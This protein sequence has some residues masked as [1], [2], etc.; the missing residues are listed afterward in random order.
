M[1]L[2]TSYL[3]LK[4]KHP[5]IVGASPMAFSIDTVRRL[6]DAGAAALVMHSLFE[7]QVDDTG[8]RDDA[9]GADPAAEAKGFP[10][11]AE[12]YVNH[13]QHVKQVTDMPIIASLNGMREGSWVSYAQYLEQAGADALELNLY[14]LPSA[15]DES[16]AV[17]EQRAFQ[18]VR[19]VRQ[20]VSI[21]VAVKLSPFFTSLPHFAHRLEEAGATA[22]VLFN[23]FFQPDIDVRNLRAEPRLG[24]STPDELLLRLRWL[25]ALHGRLRLELSVTGGVHDV[26]G[27]VKSLMAGATSVQVVSALMKNGPEYLRTL[28]EGLE[29]WMEANQ[30]ED[31]EQMRGTMSYI[32]TNAVEVVSRAHYIKT[33]QQWRAAATQ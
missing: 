20:F 10:L 13:L 21:P 25:A 9:Y 3:G 17:V 7:E 23:R 31:M 18:I 33:L 24:Y 27:V 1:N 32:H 30:F 26:D 4:L 16:S 14:F 11:N 19:L 6:E 15:E 8:G 12:E 2:S 5:V 29:D 22:L 28:V